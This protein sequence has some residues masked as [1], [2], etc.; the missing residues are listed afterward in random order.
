MR[1]TRHRVTRRPR[2]ARRTDLIDRFAEAR[3]RSFVLL[4]VLVSG[5]GAGLLGG[6]V[7]GALGA[8]YA[9]MGAVA[10]RR[11]L[12]RRRRDRAYAAMLN[13]IENASGDLRAGLVPEQL[14]AVRVAQFAAD[15]A[16]A[17]AL[18]RLEA[19]YRI[20]DALGAPLADLMDRVDA[21]LR[22][23]HR[24]GMNVRAQAAGVQATAV[25]L[26]GLP[27]VGIGLG[28][29]MGVNPAG[30]LLH[31]PVGA[32]CALSAALLQ[33]A[34]IAWTASLVRGVVTEVRA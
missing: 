15:P 3:P 2:P 12:A 22:G 17:A 23:G 30:Q 9:T 13:A 6:P 24:L 11:R 21:D 10:W 7:A 20:S 28:V 25:I 27:L 8:I 31:T 29:T 4:A 34:G 33:C 19:A 26:A 16:V 14:P 5:G 32:A 18:A 1:A